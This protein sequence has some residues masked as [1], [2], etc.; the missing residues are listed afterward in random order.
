MA[1]G[2]SLK[3]YAA[4]RKANGL[5][6]QSHVAVLKAI[7]SGRIS[8]RAAVKEGARWYIDSDI[9]DEEWAGSTD[10]MNGGN[11]RGGSGELPE[12]P[13][14]MASEEAGLGN[15]PSRNFSRA[16]RELYMARMARVEYERETGARVVAADVRKEAF[17]Q[18]RRLRDALLNMPD[19]LAHD[20]AA[21]SDPG[22][23]HLAL[24]AA[25]RET[26]EVYLKNG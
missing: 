4:H 25:I 24:S 18:A 9:A 20:L 6:G 14:M 15:I 22:A 16:V 1:Q 7:Q 19:R 8:P 21:M 5:R 26:L 23:V 12:P 3:E 13:R 11:I 2:L 17:E 10:T